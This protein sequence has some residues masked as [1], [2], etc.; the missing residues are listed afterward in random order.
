MSNPVYLPVLK[1]DEKAMCR[2]LIQYH[3]R[4]KAASELNYSPSKAKRI[5]SVLHRLSETETF[6]D[7]L[8]FLDKHPEWYS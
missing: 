1:E 5:M 6:P 3:S 8:F 4:W 2:K 7:L